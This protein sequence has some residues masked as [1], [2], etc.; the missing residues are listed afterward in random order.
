VVVGQRLGALLADAKL[1]PLFRDL[2]QARTKR[3]ARRVD[4]WRGA[5]ARRGVGRARGAARET[6]ARAWL[7]G[8]S[9]LRGNFSALDWSIV[10][11]TLALTTV[12]GL[13]FGKQATIRDFFLGGRKLPWWAVSASIIATEISGITLI[14]VPWTVYMKGGN[15]TYC[16]SR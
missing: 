13:F 16:R 3:S 8:T 1:A 2:A 11:G 5:G 12:L 4:V 10:I 15:F 9:A 14:S 6:G 7:E